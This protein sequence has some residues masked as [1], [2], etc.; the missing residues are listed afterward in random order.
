MRQ[1][2]EQHGTGSWYIDISMPDL[3]PTVNLSRRTLKCGWEQSADWIAQGQVS[4]EGGQF[5]IDAGTKRGKEFNW[6]QC[7]TVWIWN[8][9]NLIQGGSPYHFTVQSVLLVFGD[10]LEIVLTR[11]WAYDW[12]YVPVEV[13][14]SSSTPPPFL[15]FLL[16]KIEVRTLY[17]S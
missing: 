7:T 5:R 14:E 11:Y 3:Q 8:R 13:L 2:C 15:L 4:N 1:Y 16:F 9:F 10:L 17:T 6:L 12:M